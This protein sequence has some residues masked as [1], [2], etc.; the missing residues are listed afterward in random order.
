[1]P[2]ATDQNQTPRSTHN[3]QLGDSR[4]AKGTSKSL[5]IRNSA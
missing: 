4:I 2:K 1:M 5:G 3:F